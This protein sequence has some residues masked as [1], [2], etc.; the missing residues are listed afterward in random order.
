M[1]RPAPSFRAP[2]TA[3]ARSALASLV[4]FQFRCPKRRAGSWPTR[5]RQ[6]QVPTRLRRPARQL[7]DQ[8]DPHARPSA[9]RERAH[10]ALGRHRPPRMPRPAAD[11]RAQAARTRPQRVHRPL[12]PPQAAPLTRPRP[13]QRDLSLTRR[14]SVDAAAPSSAPAGPARRT[15][16]RIRTRRGMTI[17]FLHPTG[18]ADPGPSRFS[19]HDRSRVS[20]LRS[21]QTSVV[22][23]SSISAASVSG[24]TPFST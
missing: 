20:T 15:H 22:A 14:N 10:G 3:V 16:P 8:G 19:P 9:E 13:A 1:R 4:C 17:G 7:E 11:R 12:Q 5:S 24:S 21:D 18:P 23:T 6:R 2:R